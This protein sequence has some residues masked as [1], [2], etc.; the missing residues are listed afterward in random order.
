MNQDISVFGDGRQTR[1]FCYVDDL[2]DGFVR[3]MASPE[4]TTGPVNL[5]N[6][7]EFSIL[8]LADLIISLTGSSSKVIHRPL[9]QDDPRQRRPDITVAQKTLDWSPKV[10]L[11]E[12]LKK[13][14]PYFEGLL[15]AGVL[16]VHNLQH[17]RPH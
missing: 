1:S 9:P 10:S 4:T 15:S 3:L 13:T 11:A 6:P 14:I 2:V 5:G 17:G 7:G 8:E 12:G 16:N